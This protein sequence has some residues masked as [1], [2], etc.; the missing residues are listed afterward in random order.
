MRADSTIAITK[1]TK[2]KLITLKRYDRETFDD[3][4]NRLTD[5]YMEMKKQ[6][7]LDYP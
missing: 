4:L 2:E 1:K 5:S 7:R 6:Q 3:I